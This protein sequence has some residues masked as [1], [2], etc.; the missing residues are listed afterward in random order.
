MHIFHSFHNQKLNQSVTT[1]DCERSE[2]TEGVLAERREVDN[3][4]AGSNQFW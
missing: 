1:S 2:T 4:W 3:L